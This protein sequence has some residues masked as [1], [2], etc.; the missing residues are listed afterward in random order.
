MKAAD[1][2]IH[3]AGDPTPPFKSNWTLYVARLCNRLAYCFV[4][5]MYSI[6]LHFNVYVGYNDNNNYCGHVDV[7]S[8]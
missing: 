5:Y 2:S 1:A 3:V 4:H 6:G 7:Q 8:G